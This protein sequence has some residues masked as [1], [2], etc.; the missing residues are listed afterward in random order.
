ME[1]KTTTYVPF[2]LFLA[3]MIFSGL[4]SAGSGAGGII[5]V[6]NSSSY[7]VQVAFQGLGCAGCY[8]SL[9]TVCKTTV[10]NA[11]SST[12]YKYNWG[13]SS[14][15]LNIANY[16]SE[17]SDGNT[18]PCETAES[19]SE[20]LMKHKT[21]STKAYHTKTCTLT[22]K[23]GNDEFGNANNVSLSC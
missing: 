12:T 4:A 7:K 20:C 1:N 2:L 18:W 17:Y 14:T 5:K 9:C 3:S 22:D 8:K 11:G 21:V 10:L 15:W 6:V 16:H 13:V 23:S 19:D